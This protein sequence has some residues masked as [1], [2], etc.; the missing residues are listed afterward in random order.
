PSFAL[1]EPGA[2]VAQLHDRP[3]HRRERFAGLGWCVVHDLLPPMRVNSSSKRA[4]ASVADNSSSAARSSPFGPPAEFRA[5][6]GPS[7]GASGWSSSR[8]RK[9]TRPATLG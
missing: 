3:L 8:A 7:P 2:Q 9:S 6:A 4:S 5:S 1:L